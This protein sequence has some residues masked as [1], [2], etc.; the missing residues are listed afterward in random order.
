M[1]RSWRRRYGWLIRTCDGSLLSAR[2]VDDPRHAGERCLQQGDRCSD[3]LHI[4]VLVVRGCIIGTEA[5]DALDR[6]IAAATEIGER[7]VTVFVEKIDHHHFQLALHQLEYI[8][9]NAP[10][11]VESEIHH[12]ISRADH[13]RAHARRAEWSKLIDAVCARLTVSRLSPAAL[14]VV[15]FLAYG[16]IIFVAVDLV[17]A[18]PQLGELR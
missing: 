4:F 2:L 8:A 3:D 17:A 15:G 5:L 13:L 10:I 16:I 11:S 6:A 12:A 18:C 1:I 14:I 9:R 7:A